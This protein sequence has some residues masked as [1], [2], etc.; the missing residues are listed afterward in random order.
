VK[1]ALL[2]LKGLV[3]FKVRR[4]LLKQGTVQMLRIVKDLAVFKNGKPSVIWWF[5]LGLIN[6]FF[7]ERS[8][9][10]FKDGE[11]SSPGVSGSTSFL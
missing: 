3:E 6:Q 1:Q 11:E 2:G 5:E 4:S 8:P 9:E 7:F 10:T